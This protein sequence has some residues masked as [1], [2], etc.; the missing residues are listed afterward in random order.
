MWALT[1]VT[2]SAGA[3]GLGDIRLQSHLG[4]PLQAEVNVIPGDLDA[5]RSA[6]FSLA[7]EL[8]SSLPVVASARI[9]L[10]RIG[11]DYRLIITG[12]RPISE[13]AFAIGIRAGCGIELRRDFVLLPEMAPAAPVVSPLEPAATRHIPDAPSAT[14]RGMAAVAVASTE[15]ERVP[16][17]AGK[18]LVAR[19][20][21]KPRLPAPAHAAGAGDRLVLDAPPKDIKAPTNPLPPRGS[22]QDMDSRMQQLEETVSRLNY[23]VGKLDQAVDL[24]AN[25]LATQQR[26][27]QAKAAQPVSPPPSPVEPATAGLGSWL[28]LV[29]SALLG[30][31]VASLIPRLLARRR[32]RERAAEMAPLGTGRSPASPGSVTFAPGTVIFSQENLAPTQG[33]GDLCFVLETNKKAGTVVR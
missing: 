22:L 10:V 8:D 27:L 4:E 32:E 9:K 7:T 2:T 13:P 24:A 25:I 26:I 28:E 12:S 23:E 6:C 30:G 33:P 29:L 15:A 18:P 11:N 3:V 16:A 5:L 19:R 31:A 21:P 14:G 20:P 1:A 17:G